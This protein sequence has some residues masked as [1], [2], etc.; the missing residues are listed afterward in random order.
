MP[1][2]KGYKDKNGTVHPFGTP[3]GKTP[4]SQ[5]DLDQLNNGLVGLSERMQTAEGNIQELTTKSDNALSKSEA[6]I[7][8]AVKASTS[9]TDALDQITKLKLKAVYFDDS[10]AKDDNAEIVIWMEG[11]SVRIGEKEIQEY[12]VKLEDY[13]LLCGVKLN[14]NIIVINESIPLP[15]GFKGNN[16]EALDGCVILITRVSGLGMDGEVCASLLSQTLS[17]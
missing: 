13:V 8:E 17:V 10:A 3:A 6:A 4:A 5:E 11:D 1:I 16:S 7:T 2:L 9:A 15:I 12:K 14:K